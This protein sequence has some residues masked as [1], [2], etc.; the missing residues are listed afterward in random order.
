MIY[1]TVMKERIAS[2]SFEEDGLVEHNCSHIHVHVC[3]RTVYTL[4]IFFLQQANLL[5][6]LSLLAESCHTIGWKRTL[7]KGMYVYVSVYQ[8]LGFG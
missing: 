4:C 3:A 8:R 6:Y 1:D 5:P 2:I 7:C